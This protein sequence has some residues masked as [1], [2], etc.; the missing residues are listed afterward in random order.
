MMSVPVTL[1]LMLADHFL[2]L[3]TYAC[4]AV[5][6][7]GSFHSGESLNVHFLQRVSIA[8]YAKRCISYRKSVRLTD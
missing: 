5:I 4:S 8:C 6:N 7:H 1:Y 2:T 3:A